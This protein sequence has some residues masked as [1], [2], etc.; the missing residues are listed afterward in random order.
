MRALK[1]N[2]L[3]QRHVELNE[4]RPALGI[5]TEISVLTRRYIGECGRIQP[6]RRPVDVARVVHTG[7]DVRTLVREP[8]GAGA[9]RAKEDRVRETAS[10]EENAVQL[11]A[12][13]PATLTERQLPDTVE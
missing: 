9:A 6:A 8:A 11:P 12:F 7:D 2:V 10:S 13:T 5:A 4:M 3:E 1:R